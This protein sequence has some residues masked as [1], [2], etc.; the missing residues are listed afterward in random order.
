[1]FRLEVLPHSGA[2]DS[3]GT[4]TAGRA[5]ESSS[6]SRAP[7]VET[8]A[9]TA[10]APLPVSEPP[11]ARILPAVPVPA[12]A[13]LRTHWLGRSSRCVHWYRSRVSSMATSILPNWIRNWLVISTLLVS[14][15]SAYVVTRPLG[16]LYYWLFVPCTSWVV[17]GPGEGVSARLLEAQRGSVSSE[18]AMGVRVNSVWRN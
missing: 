3:G 13:C 14:W 6:W 10:A 7:L 5:A 15:D 1:M 11:F 16:S 2:A 12:V 17:I 8:P 18:C 9:E 4:V